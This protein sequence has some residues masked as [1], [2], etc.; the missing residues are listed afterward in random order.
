MLDTTAQTPYLCL[1]DLYHT[2]IRL[3]DGFRLPNRMVE[4]EWTRHAEGAR[5][6]DRYGTIPRV[7]V[8]NLGLCRTIEVGLEGRRVRKVVVRTE[9][10]DTNDMILVLVP[11]P[12]KW[13]VKTV[14]INQKNDTHRTLDRSKYVA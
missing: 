7:P 8:V 2:D 5:H 14:W 4:L 1:M 9:L 11:G 12:G 3:P 6:N 10:D 13:T